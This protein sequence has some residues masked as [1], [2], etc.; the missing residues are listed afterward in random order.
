[1]CGTETSLGLVETQVVHVCEGGLDLDGGR[2]LESVAVAYEQY[3]A[4][5]AARDNVILV[6][7]AL[8]GGA[9]AAGWHAGAT[10]PGW[11]D[12]MIGPGKAFDTNRYCVV[13][14]NVLGSCYGSTGPASIEALTGRPYGRRFPVV[15][16]GDMVRVQKALLDTLRIPTLRAVAGG[17]MG[18]MQALQW[19]VSYPE[20]IR[21]VIALATTHRHS[22]QQIA[23]DEIARRAVQADPHWRDGD[24][25]DGEPPR[26]GLA[27]A[28]MIGH[29]TYL[30]D[31]GMH[32]K[33]GRRLRQNAPAY[34][35]EPEFEVE[36]YLRHQARS[37]VER[38]DANSL[39]YLSRAMDYFDLEA[40]GRSL[41]DT[42]R[43]T[44]AAFLLLTFSSDWL[45]PPYQLEEVAAAA[46]A[47]GR[48]VSYHQIESVYGHDAFL[49]EHQ[50]QEPVVRAFFDGIGGSD[51]VE[52]GAG[53]T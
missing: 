12:V 45:Y 8:S 32:G 48:T 5:N 20:T 25:Y 16:I 53:Q 19:A 42:F 29:V 10:K 39:M 38:F 15:T 36:H 50:A 34:G 47:A 33:F 37:F 7:H 21:S 18:G 9:H 28:R 43:G 3:G 46:T 44:S 14:T 41:A 13:S 22:P 17:S 40:D 30:S 6:C 2:R 35:F 11:W 23:F 4:L 51:G 49:L 52:T 27:V 26:N 31:R 1:M 24:Y